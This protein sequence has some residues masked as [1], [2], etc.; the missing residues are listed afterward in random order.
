MVR[1]PSR[2]AVRAMRQAISPRLAIRTDLNIERDS[3]LFIA[4]GRSRLGL[5]TPRR[6]GHARFALRLWLTIGLGS[7][8]VGGR[9]WQ[10]RLGIHDAHR[11]DRCS[12][13]EVVV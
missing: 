13:R 12:R 10:R 2:L 1:R 4:R 11:R 9:L 6:H 5:R 3:T 8:S 7:L